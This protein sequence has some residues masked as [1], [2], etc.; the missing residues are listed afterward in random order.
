[1]DLPQRISL[2]IGESMFGGV[3]VLGLAGCTSSVARQQG[4]GKGPGRAESRRGADGSEPNLDNVDIG[5]RGRDRDPFLAPK[6]LMRHDEDQEEVATS[7]DP[8]IRLLTYRT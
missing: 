3:A 8:T 7:V 2:R 1:M 5:N 6:R 4:E